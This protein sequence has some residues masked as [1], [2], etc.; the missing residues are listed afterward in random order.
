MHDFC[1][2]RLLLAMALFDSI[3]FIQV[4]V[5]KHQESC[6]GAIDKNN[7]ASHHFV[8]QHLGRECGAK[9]P[10]REPVLRHKEKWPQTHLIS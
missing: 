2:Q 4:Y 3:L 6:V 8:V 1:R 5:E 10:T 9:R 7:I